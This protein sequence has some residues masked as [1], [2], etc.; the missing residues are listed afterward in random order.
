MLV[1]FISRNSYGAG[2]LVGC[3]SPGDGIACVDEYD[4]YPAIEDLF[5]FACSYWRWLHCSSPFIPIPTDARWPPDQAGTQASADVRAGVPNS[6]RSHEAL[7]SCQIGT[8]SSSQDA[9]FF[10][11]GLSPRA[12]RGEVPGIASGVPGGPIR[13]PVKATTAASHMSCRESGATPSR[14]RRRISALS[15]FTVPNDFFSSPTNLCRY[16]SC[17]AQPARFS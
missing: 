10:R 2:Q 1:H 12:R 13:P 11:Y 5:R 9:S 16:S 7:G 17:C 6:F 14:A 8:Q 15:L 3:L 4:V